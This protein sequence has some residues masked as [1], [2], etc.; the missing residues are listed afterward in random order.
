MK[1]A[2]PAALE[3]LS[4]LIDQIRKKDGIKEKKLGIFYRKSKSFLHFHEDPAGVFADLAIGTDFDRY[5][6]NTKQ[7]WRVLLSAIDQ[8]LDFAANRNTVPV[9]RS[10]SPSHSSTAPSAAA[11][12]VLRQKVRA[13]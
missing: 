1:H 8:A 12:A 4:D 7:E 3:E 13:G 6:V 5:P 9:Q 11:E 2:T 10:P